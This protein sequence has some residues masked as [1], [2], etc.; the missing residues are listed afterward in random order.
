MTASI[1]LMRCGDVAVTTNG[2]AAL[3]PRELPFAHDGFGQD[4]EWVAANFTNATEIAAA[5]GYAAWVDAQVGEGLTNGLYKLTVDVT[6]DPPETVNLAIGDHS[7]AITNAG[8]YVFLLG[9]GVRY[10]VSAS[11]DCVTNFIYS[12]VDDIPATPRMNDPEM[13]LLGGGSPSDGKWVADLPRLMLPPLCNYVLFEPNLAVLPGEWHPSW[14]SPA[15]TFTAI[16]TDLP[17]F[18]PPPEFAWTSHGSA[19]VSISSPAGATTSISCAFPDSFGSS[20]SLQLDV[21]MGAAALR[22][23]FCCEIEQ[24]NVGDYDN[25]PPEGIA[26]DDWTLGLS[27]GASPGV[28][29]FERG[30]ANSETADLACRYRTAAGGTFTL[31][32]SGDSCD[33]VDGSF[34]AVSSGHTWEI[35]EA[36]EGVRH[37]TVSYP[38][39]SS[40]PSGTVFSVA[41]EPYSGTNVMSGAA[42]VVFVEWETRTVETWPGDRHRKELGVGEKVDINFLPTIPFSSVYSSVSSGGI[43]PNGNANYQYT[44]PTNAC[45]DE[46]VFT[47]LTG[48]CC[49][50]PFSI[51]E[52]TGSIV[53]NVASN[54]ENHLNIAGTFEIY[55]D[56]VLAPTNVSFKNRIE[57]A[58]IGGVAA[59]ATG[60]FSSPSLAGL[61]D[62]GQHG[63]ARW[64]KIEDENFAGMDTIGPGALYPPFSDGSFTWPIPNHWRMV[65]D[66]GVGK[67]FCNN[68][69]HFAITTNGT[70][71]VW[72]FGKRATR[73]LNSDTVIITNEEMP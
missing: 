71:S 63:A 13:R 1:E 37:F 51:L 15:K 60:Y 41:F 56:L 65:G 29:F 31:T 53:V 62:H 42:S 36:C 16:L 33:V 14:L 18:A 67:W 59:N 47:A 40:S 22:A 21:A 11:S 19:N 39:C 5:G 58:E 27:I 49:P 26:E 46:V 44:A 12:A 48:D 6:D 34:H 45:N 52:P 72:K 55:F 9:K 32:Y 66:S 4:A 57:V 69:Q 43:T 10:D 38:F 23:N 54:L 73:I 35:D 3:L 68:D 70:T 8:E 30:S 2:V 64:V 50:I 20:A 28:V 7:I 25:L 61:L 17:P 24:Y